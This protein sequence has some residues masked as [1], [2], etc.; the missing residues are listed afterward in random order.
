MTLVFSPTSGFYE[1]SR[2]MLWFHAEDEGRLVRCGITRE[3]LLGL[4]GRND[5]SKDL[6]AIYLEH[7]GRIRR[8][9][10]RKYERGDLAPDGAI[11]LDRGQV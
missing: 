10:L 5:S 1:G 11:V 7:I 3:A 4:A 6:M 9:A 2:R 8:A